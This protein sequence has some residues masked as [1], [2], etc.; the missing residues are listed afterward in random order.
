MKNTVTALL[1]LCFAFAANAQHLVLTGLFDGPLPGGQPKGVELYVLEAIPD[2][3]AYGLGSANNGQGSD[4]QEYTFPADS[5]AAGTYIWVTSDADAFQSFFGF[6]PTYVD[7]FGAVNVNGDD[8]MEL[9]YNGAV[10]DVFGDINTDGS[11]QP[12]EYLDSWAYRMDGTGPDGDTFVLGNWFFGGPNQFDNTNTNDEAAHP[13]PTGTYQPTGTQMLDAQ[14]DDASVEQGMM[15]TIDVLAN[16]FLPNGWES[17]SIVESPALGSAS[18]NTMG[19]AVEYVAPTDNCNLTDVFTYAVCDSVSCDTATVEVEITCPIQYPAYDIA[20]VTTEDVQGVADSLGVLCTLTGVVHGINM[21]PQGLQFF[22]LDAT[23]GIMV[24]E[25][26]NPFGYTV[27]EGD[28]LMIKGEIDQYRG[29]TQLRPHELVLLSQNN[30]LQPVADV[31]MLSEAAEGRLVR[32]MNVSLVDPAQWLGDGSSFNVEITDGTV[33]DTVR[34]DNDCELASMP[35]PQGV[36]H[37]T[38]LGGQYAPSS[39][40]PFLSGYQL[41]PR[42]AADIELVTAVPELAVDRGITLWPVPVTDVLHVRT[43]LN[44]QGVRVFD[45]M[46]RVMTVAYDLPSAQLFVQDLLSGVYSLL[47]HTQQGT[48]VARFVK[49]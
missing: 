43:E 25:F 33:V 10:I 24:F 31:P 46:G 42:Y 44:L 22:L 35:A 23:G 38:G 6:A 19:D 34:I 3:S 2:L 11:G 4:G 39:S 29:Q 20:T 13:M 36:F 14:D 41:F 21:R 48:F 1:S 32:R 28:E 5:V 9:F 45:V 40:P 30:A 7:S 18:L 12:W 16:D 15:V 49:Q 47:L 37:I 26:D 8:A 27:Q 17:L